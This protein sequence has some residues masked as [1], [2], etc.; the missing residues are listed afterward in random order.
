MSNSS[1][2]E[3]DNMIVNFNDVQIH[4]SKA[5]QVTLQTEQ[6]IASTCLCVGACKFKFVNGSRAGDYGFIPLQPLGRLTTNTC[7]SH[8]GNKNYV[9]LHNKLVN[10]ETPIVMALNLRSLVI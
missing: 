7:P 4:A 10:I 9:E 2:I 3:V 8:D 5:D 6:K 1:L